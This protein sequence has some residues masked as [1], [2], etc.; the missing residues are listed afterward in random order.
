MGGT[1]LLVP[2]GCELAVIAVTG[3]K[4]SAPTTDI[5]LVVELA[6][7]RWDSTGLHT[8]GAIEGLWCKFRGAVKFEEECNKDGRA[9]EAR[10]R[11]IF[12]P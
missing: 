2:G 7:A 8:D 9:D 1:S 11:L 12:W 5:L 4:V 6:R 3:S 10:G